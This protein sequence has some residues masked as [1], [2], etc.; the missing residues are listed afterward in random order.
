MEERGRKGGMS[1]S[2]HD[3]DAERKDALSSP[4]PL[5]AMTSGDRHRLLHRHLKS[6]RLLHRHLKRALM[7]PMSLGEK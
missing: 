4:S 1:T 5:Y 6:H 2:P 7:D 3:D